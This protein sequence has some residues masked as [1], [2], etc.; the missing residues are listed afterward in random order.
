MVQDKSPTSPPP[1]SFVPAPS[2]KQ[3]AAQSTNTVYEEALA[4]EAPEEAENEEAPE[5]AENE[6]REWLRGLDSGRGILPEHPKGSVIGRIE[7][8]LWEAL[9]VKSLGHRLLLAK[10]ILKL[11]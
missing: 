4:K 11:E 10:G 5:E 3:A 7:Q 6:V 9:D 2:S 8:S 1:G